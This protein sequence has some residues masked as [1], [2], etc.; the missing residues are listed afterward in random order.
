VALADINGDGQM[1]I[2]TG[3]YRGGISFFK[4]DVNGTIGIN[5]EEKFDIIIYPN[6]ANNYLTI[7][8]NQIQNLSISLYDITGRILFTNTFDNK[9]IIDISKFTSGIYFVEVGKKDSKL[10]QKIIKQ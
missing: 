6:P 3:N 5:E 2:F 10:V 7:D 8:G 4:G 1:D 9:I